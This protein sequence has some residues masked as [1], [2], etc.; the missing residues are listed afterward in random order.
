M[1]KLLDTNRKLTSLEDMFGGLDDNKEFTSNVESRQQQQGT[2]QSITL[3]IACLHPKRNHK[4]QINL[5]QKNQDLLQSIKEFGV[6]EPI[7]VRPLETGKAETEVLTKV[8]Q[9][10]ILAGHRRTMMAKEAGLTEVPV[11][12]KNGL[13]EAEADLIETE[14]NLLQRSWADMS[15]SERA[16]VLNSHYNATNYKGVRKG[17]LEQ[18]NA[19]IKTLASPVNSMANE[20]LS[21][22]ATK[23]NLRTSGEAYELSKDTVARYLRIYTL[24]DELKERMDMDEIGLYAGVDVSYL[25]EEHQS[26]L[27]E[28]L[29]IYK[30]DT[31]NAQD[32]RKLESQ[33]KLDEESM[34]E[35]LSGKQLKKPGRP[36]SF[37]IQGNIIQ[38]YFSEDMKQKEI[39]GIID[40]ALEAYFKKEG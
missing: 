20:G 34:K 33:G 36:K 15:H 40:A 28:L 35:I 8:P 38:K 11:V 27:D 17:F 19:E 1:S 30:M 21:L 39:E 2:E 25:T 22:I 12:I 31:K 7:I 32:L 23:G 37:K 6:L 14:T 5:G 4:F 24:I 9:Y 26:R 3:P 13:S 10:E 16:E 29:D 18:I